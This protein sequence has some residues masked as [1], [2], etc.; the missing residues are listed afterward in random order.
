MNEFKNETMKAILD[1]YSCRDFTGEPITKEQAGA[2]AKAALAAPSAMNLQPW[3][4][5]VITDKA[6]ID[7]YDAHAMAILKDQSG[8]AYKRMMDRGGKLFYNAPCLVVIA[9]DATDYATLDCGIA[10]Q[11]VALAAH[12]L[13]LASVICGMARIPLAGPKAEE[14]TKRLQ[15]P[16]GYNFGMSVCV[17]IANTGKAPH[18]LDNAKVTYI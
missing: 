18:E 16:D 2:L 4:I 10:T 6:L 15:I 5:I 9:K 12:S 7:E 3:H 8:D 14:W 13:G 1:R 11:N 17:G